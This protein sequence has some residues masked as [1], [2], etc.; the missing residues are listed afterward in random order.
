MVAGTDEGWFV[1][2]LA[3]IEHS[4]LVVRLEGT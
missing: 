2:T 3:G 1:R 4:G